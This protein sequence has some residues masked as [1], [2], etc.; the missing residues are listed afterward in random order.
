MHVIITKHNRNNYLRIT[1]S[2]FMEAIRDYPEVK[3]TIFDDNSQVDNEPDIVH[4][5]DLD[6]IYWGESNGPYRAVAKAIDQTFAEYDE[7]SLVIID[8]D[9]V[10]H[11]NFVP[12]VN[13]MS[14][15][16]PDMGFGSVF[17][18][19]NH[20]DI[21]A[22]VC[23]AKYLQK[24]TIGGLGV[25]VNRDAWEWHKQMTKE[26]GE[27]HKGWDWNFCL[28]LNETD[29]WKIY[30]TAQSYVEHIGQTGSHSGPACS[31]DKAIRFLD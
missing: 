12:V 28:W 17:N 13:Q 9:C 27:K 11:P 6:V 30:S 24:K 18:T 14:I 22:E 26:H 20:S 2:T 7:S 23:N 25:I 5:H 3:I 31:I 19:A 10:I 21:I 15:D 4:E 29:N 1:L 8:S 16:L